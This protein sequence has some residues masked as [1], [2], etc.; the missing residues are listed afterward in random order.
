MTVSGDVEYNID[1]EIQ[2]IS[3]ICSVLWAQFHVN[4][5]QVQ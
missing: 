4:Q 5:A 2:S 1:Y 3:A